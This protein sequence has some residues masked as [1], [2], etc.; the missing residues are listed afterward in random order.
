MPTL[1]W[2]GK[3][4]VLNHHREVPYHLLKVDRGLSSGEPGSRN[5]IVQ[6]DNLLALKALVPYY[7]GKV[8]CIYIDPPY[9]TIRVQISCLSTFRI[10]ETLGIAQF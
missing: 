7:A 2:I 4:A 10:L 8:R 3:K 5:L 1:E 6:G 9:N